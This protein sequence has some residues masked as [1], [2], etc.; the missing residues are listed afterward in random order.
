MP[1][2]HR[3]PKKRTPIA[4]RLGAAVRQRRTQLTLTQE[5]LAEQAGVSK[6]Y[7]GTIER[8]E[9]ELSVT[10][11]ISFADGLSCRASVLMADAGY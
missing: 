4:K 3:S 11:L 6:N 5:E 7:V 8:G 9:Q 2:R 1:G 10:L